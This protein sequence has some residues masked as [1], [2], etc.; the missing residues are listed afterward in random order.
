MHASCEQLRARLGEL[1]VGPG[2]VLPQ[3]ALQ[4]RIVEPGTILR[5]RAAFAQERFVDLLDVD[6][7]VLDGLDGTGD[8]QEAAG[9]R[10]R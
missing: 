1:H 8:L 9:G 2:L 3:P 10:S 4:D 6:A 5:W 7:T